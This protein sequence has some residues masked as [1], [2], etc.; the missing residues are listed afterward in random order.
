MWFV[1]VSLGWLIPNTLNLF[2]GGGWRL[3]EMN[4]ALLGAVMLAPLLEEVVFRGGLQGSLMGFLAPHGVA[5]RRLA[6]V[7]L[8]QSIVFALCHFNVLDPRTIR[9]VPFALHFLGGA[10]LGYLAY[11]TNSIWPG[12][13]IHAMG[14]MSAYMTT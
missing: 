14:N 2:S 1:M 3:P 8:L 4:R 6:L 13:V 9:L 12:I 11:R 10:A 7:I 5:V